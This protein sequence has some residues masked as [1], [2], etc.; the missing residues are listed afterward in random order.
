MIAGAGLLTAGLGQAATGPSRVG[1]DP[2]IGTVI[3]SPTSGTSATTTTWTT[4][5]GCPTGF[6]SSAVL[7]EVNLNSTGTAISSPM[8]FTAVSGPFN[9]TGSNPVTS[10]PLIEDVPDLLSAANVNPGGSTEWVLKCSSVPSGLGLVP[11]SGVYFQDI[12]V[13]LG[14]TGTTYSVGTSTGT[15]TPTP[16]DTSSGTPTPT[17]TDTSSGTPTPT[18]TD[19]SSGTPTPTPTD[20]S[21]GTP[22]PT[23][24]DTSTGTAAPIPA[25]TSSV[26]PSGAPATG[27][28]GAS[29]PGDGNN[30]LT[31]LG[32]TLLA[33]SAAS[34]GLALRRKRLPALEA[35][36]DRAKPGGNS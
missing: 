27:A 20:T 22:T 16:T 11:T 4:T 26:L 31:G 6:Q 35:R 5:D 7:E 24:T 9:L 2:T 33:G 10:Q 23:P 19:T 12:D 29:L 8:T 30:V 1:T 34:I 36:A 25:A 28:G 21:T 14:S 13:S 3:L 17:P 15:P 18:P 32:A